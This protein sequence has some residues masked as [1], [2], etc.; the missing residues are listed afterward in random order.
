MPPHQRP[1]TNNALPAGNPPSGMN[2]GSPMNPSSSYGASMPA[3]NSPQDL[4]ND[5]RALNSG[6][7]VLGQ[8]VQSIIRNEKMLS[9][10]FVVLSKRL[11]TFSSEARSNKGNEG[12]VSSP[13][14]ESMKRDL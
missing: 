3:P 6:L 9:Q 1:T 8:R 4:V 11:E 7:M 2:S 12:G 14:I 13:Q 10:N 5:I